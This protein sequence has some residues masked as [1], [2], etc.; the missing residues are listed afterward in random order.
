[1]RWVIADTVS[2]STR[3]VLLAMDLRQLRLSMQA[4]VEDPVPLV[5]PRGDG[6]IPRDP[7][8][9]ENLVGAFNGAFKTEHGEYG[10]V[11][12]RRVLL[13]PRPRA[14]TVATLDDGRVA[15]RR[16]RGGRRRGGR[17]DGPV[18]GPG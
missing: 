4:G 5:G 16:L 7:A 1:M 10:M 2:P 12:D 15:R 8:V 13:P 18:R 14:A 17:R 9:L 6:R 3:V 11:V